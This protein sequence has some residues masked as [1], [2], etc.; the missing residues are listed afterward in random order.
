MDGYT[1]KRRIGELGLSRNSALSFRDPNHEE[2]S[3]QHSNR[4]R[5]STRH[6]SMKSIQNNSTEKSK[7]TKPPFQSSN[8]ALASSSSF[9]S[10][11]MFRKS[12]NEHRNQA[13]VDSKEE[14]YWD[15]NEREVETEDLDGHGKPTL[16][17]YST[18]ST[19]TPSSSNDSS[20]MRNGKQINQRFIT[21][22]VQDAASSFLRRSCGSRSGSQSSFSGHN[23]RAVS[24]SREVQDREGS[25]NP[26]I[27]PPEY[28]LKK[29]GS[30][31]SR[32]QSGRD[33]AISVRTRRVSFTGE[34]SR[35]RSS[36]S[37]IENNVQL[38]EHIPHEQLPHA[39]PSS[40]VV[41]HGNRSRALSIERPS[42]FHD[43]SCAGRPGSS[44]SSSRNRSISLSECAQVLLAFERIE[45]NDLT[46]EELVVLEANLLSGWLNFYD[47]HRDLRLDIDN[48]SYEELLELEEKMGTVSTALSEEAL[49]KCLK[50]STYR[51]SFSFPGIPLHGDCDTKCSICQEDYVT[52][53]EVGRLTC[54][55]RYHV[56]C[57]QQWLRLKNL[58]PICKAPAASSKQELH[59]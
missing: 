17:G 12:Y 8:S 11:K 5:C 35:M 42:A 53:E 16:Q 6:N 29:E 44:S 58:C 47:Q 4:I 50:I 32:I 18:I 24:V 36:E 21:S 7:Y 54:D 28:Q 37:E 38:R 33:A 46:Y 40:L 51:P 26:V 20:A 1:G 59:H 49:S 43:A 13:S 10:T 25:S 19:D 27:S 9:S 48:M 23:R 2:R 57:I 34:N 45:Q 39:P 22:T 3:F 56:E 31:K 55:H 14:L 30:S 41:V 52:G 15:L